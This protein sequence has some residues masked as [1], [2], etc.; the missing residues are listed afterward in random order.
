MLVQE[1]FDEAFRDHGPDFA[2]ALIDARDIA[3]SL[4]AVAFTQLR[5][6]L[7]SANFDEALLRADRNVTKGSFAI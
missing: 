4:W 5:P 1:L 2:Q 7:T 6:D 3:G